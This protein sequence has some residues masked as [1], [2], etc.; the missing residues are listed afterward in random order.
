MESKIQTRGEAIVGASAFALLVT[1]FLP[2]YTVHGSRRMIIVLAFARKLPDV[3]SAWHAYPNLRFA[4]FV[5][6]LGAL[7]VP[8]LAATGQ[9]HAM[10]TAAKLV[11]VGGLVMTVLH[12]YQLVDQPGE[13]RFRQAAYGAYL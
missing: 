12:I 5:L 7:I 9:R 11:A 4:L 2:W 8:A 13:D 6:A 10:R 1:M 3:G